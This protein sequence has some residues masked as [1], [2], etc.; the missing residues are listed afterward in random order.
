MVQASLLTANSSGSDHGY[1]PVGA[2]G[3]LD[4]T[5]NRIVVHIA[6]QAEP[7]GPRREPRPTG[8]ATSHQIKIGR[9]NGH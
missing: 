5:G 4:D 3:R 7:A 6:C 1:M 2:A 9:A 8:M